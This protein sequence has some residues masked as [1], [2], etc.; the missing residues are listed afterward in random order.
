M[1]AKHNGETNG[2][3]RSVKRADLGLQYAER[4]MQHQKAVSDIDQP[5]ERLPNRRSQVGQPKVVA[6]RHH[7]KQDDQGQEAE[8]KGT[9]ANAP[10]TG[11]EMRIPRMGLASPPA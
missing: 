1:Q 7:Q 5:V 2:H 10:V 3:T 11:V 9:P 6:G 4:D 8:R